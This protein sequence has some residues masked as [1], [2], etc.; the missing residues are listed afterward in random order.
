MLR[1]TAVSRLAPERL[2]IVRQLHYVIEVALRILTPHVEHMHQPV[3]AARDRLVTL[4]PREFAFKRPVAVELPSLNYL[5]RSQRP[6][7]IAR[8]PDLTVGSAP[9]RAEQ[10]VVRDGGRRK[11][12]FVLA[13]NLVIPSLAAIGRSPP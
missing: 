1:R 6:Q 4:D 8:Q 10:R 9:D 13:T 11:H 7:D 3:S 2:R 12:Q 5:T